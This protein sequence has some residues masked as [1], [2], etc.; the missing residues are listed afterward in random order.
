MLCAARLKP[1]YFWLVQRQH[2]LAISGQEKDTEA[3]IIH[4][5]TKAEASFVLDW[6]I[7]DGV[8]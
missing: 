3:H 8:P 4:R 2:F 7:K 5:C 1:H 6:L